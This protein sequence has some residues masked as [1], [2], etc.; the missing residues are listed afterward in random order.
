MRICT[1]QVP[2]SAEIQENVNTISRYLEIAVSNRAEVV[3]FPEMMLTEYDQHLY[4]FF[5]DPTWYEQVQT[6][7]DQVWKHTARVGIQALVGTPYHV[8]SGYNNGIVHIEPDAGVRHVGGRLATVGWERWGFVPLSRKDPVT[9]GGIDCGFVVCNEVNDLAE[10][11]GCGLGQS[12]VIFWPSITCNHTNE[13]GEIVKDNS[14]EGG[15][16]IATTFGVVAVQSS[17]INQ[18]RPLRPDNKLGGMVIVD[19]DGTV[20]QQGSYDEEGF[21]IHEV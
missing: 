1:V 17:Y 13:A 5:K 15:V 19:A 4:E 7:L 16:S 11:A 8:G 20:L 18:I 21:L 12:R 9:V 14:R 6:G 2:M 10:F 3:S